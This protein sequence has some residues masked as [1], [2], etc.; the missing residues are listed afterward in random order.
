[1]IALIEAARTKGQNVTADQYSWTAAET[2]LDA[3][4][5]PRWAQAGGFEAMIRRFDDPTDLAKI[6]ADDGLTPALAQKL[7][8]SDAPKQPE[9]VGKRLSELAVQWGI[10]PLD[11][12]I[13]VLKGGETDIV[14][15]VMSEPDIVKIMAKPWVMSSSDGADGG[16]PRG[17]ASYPRLWEKYVIAEKV[18][19]PVQFV[20]R[21]TGLEADTF[22]LKGRGY[23]KTGYSADIAVIDPRMYHARA[24][25]IEP[26][27]LSTGVVDVIINGGVEVEDGK[28]TGILSGRPL[29]KTPPAGTCP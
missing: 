23:I 21:S 10:A 3:V 27:L 22:G 2:G 24:T 11:A 13:R 12:A 1:V 29:T 16:H 18:L 14:V 5:I 6:H 20:H 8:I 7:M 19:T 25:Y 17:Y 4:A 26:K 15:F 28:P 9:L